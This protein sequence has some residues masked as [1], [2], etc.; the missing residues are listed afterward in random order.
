MD[1]FYSCCLHPPWG[2]ESMSSF[3]N[4][5][6]YVLC[7]ITKPFFDRCLAGVGNLGKVGQHSCQIMKDK[8]DKKHS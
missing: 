3:F 2:R 8:K 7:L 4:Q 1:V 6:Y 5:R